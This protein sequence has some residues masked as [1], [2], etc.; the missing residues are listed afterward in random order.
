[1]ENQLCSKIIGDVSEYEKC[2]IAGALFKVQYHTWSL[3]LFTP[4]HANSVS[5]INFHFKQ[6]TIF[7][8][9]INLN[10]IYF[11]SPR[12]VARKAGEEYILVPV[13]NSIADMSSVYT[14]NTTGAF[15]WERLD[16]IKNVRDIISDVEE[17]FMVDG[18]TALEDVLSF[19]HDLREYLIIAE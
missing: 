7:E 14:L 2:S 16:G 12:I 13:S 8:N 5:F 11:R 15:I 10:T 3:L 4:N 18:K 17:E 19:I 9:M 6:L 1:M